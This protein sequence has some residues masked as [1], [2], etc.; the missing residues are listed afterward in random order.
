[1]RH[2]KSKCSLVKKS[3]RTSALFA[4][5]RALRRAILVGCAHSALRSGP[6][7]DDWP[8]SLSAHRIGHRIRARGVG[9]RVR[10][11]GK[12][13][14]EMG[15]VHR[16]GDAQTRFPSQI[17]TGFKHRALPDDPGVGQDGHDRHFLR[18]DWTPALEPCFLFLP[19]LR[20]LT[21]SRYSGDDVEHSHFGGCLC[22][23]SG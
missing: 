16:S 15:P 8:S 9:F 6:G 10:R 1:M 11:E 12:I 2:I 19:R 21:S 4:I 20:G 13:R 14:S 17:G 3:P 18:L 22:T 7:R 5:E 23:W